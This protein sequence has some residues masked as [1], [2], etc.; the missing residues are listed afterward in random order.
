MLIDHILLREISLRF[1]YTLTMRG[2]I[3]VTSLCGGNRGS[4]VTGLRRKIGVHLLGTSMRRL[5]YLWGIWRSPVSCCGRFGLPTCGISGGRASLLQWIGVGNCLG[6][7]LIS[8]WHGN[9]HP[10]L[11]S[12]RHGAS[13]RSRLI[14]E[15]GLMR[16]HALVR[17]SWERNLV[18]ECSRDRMNDGRVDVWCII[19]LRK[20]WPVELLLCRIEI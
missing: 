10:G 12:D 1:D 17:H 20:N 8:F 15:E 5:S 4:V 6:L 19:H 2:P 11:R 3:T 18:L 13:R 14:R 7:V 9:L 16:H